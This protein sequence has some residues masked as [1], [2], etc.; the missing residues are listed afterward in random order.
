MDI[1]RQFTPRFETAG[2]ADGGGRRGSMFRALA[3]AAV[4]LIIGVTSLEAAGP[5]TLPS[6][7]KLEQWKTKPAGNWITGALQNNNSDYIEGETVPFR[8]EIPS[9]INAGSYRFSVCRNYADGARR[10]YL[11]IAPY[12]T[13]RPATPGGTIGS[14]NGGF[15]AISATID[16]VTDVDAQGNCKAGDREAIVTITKAAGTAYVLWGGHLASPLDAG[17]GAGNGAASWP[18][19][20]LHMKLSEPSKDVA[21]NTCQSLATPTATSTTVVT[22]TSAPPTVT[23]TVVLTATVT[24]TNTATGTPVTTVAPPPPGAATA[25]ATSSPTLTATSTPMPTGTQ[26]ARKSHTPTPASPAAT[27]TAAAEAAASTPTPVSGTAGQVR[28]RQVPNTGCPVESNS[29][30]PWM[31]ILIAAIGGAAI[32]TVASGFAVKKYR[33]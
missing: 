28:P 19:A 20:S 26:P 11:A 16:S 2:S 25:T 6:S 8:L 3:L 33:T 23:V 13:S 29:G 31:L 30:T 17:V 10:G 27:N 9:K 4:V 18:G 24:A 32:A 14:S 7:V 22:S 5:S 15:S 21:I 12:N 1:N